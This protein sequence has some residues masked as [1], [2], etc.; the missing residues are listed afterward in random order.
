MCIAIQV[1]IS[2]EVTAGTLAAA[3]AALACCTRRLT[4]L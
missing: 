4:L 2:D 1:S 3:A